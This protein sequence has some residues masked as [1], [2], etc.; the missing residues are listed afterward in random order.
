MPKYTAPVRDTQ[1]ILTE[2]LGI[3]KYSNLPGFDNAAPVVLSAVL[4]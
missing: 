1:F 3:E 4:E 2:G